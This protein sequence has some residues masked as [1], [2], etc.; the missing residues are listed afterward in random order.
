[1]EITLSDTR[2]KELI[3]EVQAYFRQEQDESIGDLKAEML[4][5]FFIARLGPKIYNQA[6]ADANTFIQE[7]LIDL[8][9]ILY[10]PE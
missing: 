10:I 6:I 3:Q 1:M 7:K 9:G 8:E 4:V 2:K 5:E